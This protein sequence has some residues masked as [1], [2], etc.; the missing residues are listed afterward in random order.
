MIILKEGIKEMKRKV[1]VCLILVMALILTVPALAVTATPNQQLFF[2]TGPTTSY[3]GIGHMPQ[4]TFLTA[5][6]YEQG[7]GV[8]WVLCE[9]TRDGKLERAYTGLK[10]MTVNGTIPWAN[11]LNVATSV[12]YT[13]TVYGGPGDYYINRSTLY[14]GSYV[15][16]L[17]Y[18]GDYAYIDFTDPVQ[19]EPSRGWVYYTSLACGDRYR[20]GGSTNSGNS[21]GSNSGGS[22]GGGSV[23]LYD[24]TLIYVDNS[25][26]TYLRQ[27]AFSSSASLT[28]I[29]YD[30]ILVSYATTT[31]GFLYV[32]YGNYV[33]YVDQ[34]DVSLCYISNVSGNT[35]GGNTGGGQSG[36]PQNTS[37]SL[38]GQV[39]TLPNDVYGRDGPFTYLPYQFILPKG[40]VV[41][42]TNTDTQNGQL[43]Y[44]VHF[45]DTDGDEDWA[46]IRADF[47]DRP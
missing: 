26:G 43:W 2:R 30:S 45:I 1:S 16:L 17:R 44:A 19:G 5:I 11:H 40:L 42:I 24:G 21:G 18:D 13:V 7:S 32:S 15:T 34:W 23:S 29:P 41:W 6:E 27:N 33:G 36:G 28:W 39:F 12:S 9:Y 22:Y 35:G 37:D 8:T 14:S 20:P 10:R 38:I 47:T 4:S 25:S 31:N 3:V 46:W